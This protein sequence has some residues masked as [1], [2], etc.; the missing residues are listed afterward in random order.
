ME[1]ASGSSETITEKKGIASGVSEKAVLITGISVLLG[2]CFDYSFYGKAPGINFPLYIILLVAGLLFIAKRIKQEVTKQVFWLLTPLLFFSGMVS[3]RSSHLLNFLD[4]TASFLLLLIIA[5]LM[6]GR[7]VRDFLASDYLKLCL[8]PLRFIRPCKHTFSVLT[9]VAVLSGRKNTIA[10]I[11]KGLILSVPVLLLFLLLFSSADLIFHK[12][13]VNLVTFHIEAETI[14][15]L[16]L[17]II[18]SIILAGAFS[19][20]FREV[21]AAVPRELG[22]EGYKLGHI[23]TSILLGS[24]NILFFIF[25]FIQLRYLFGGQSNILLQGFTYAV[26]ARR[27]FFELI[28]VAVFSFLLLWTTEKSIIQTASGHTILFKLLAGVLI[29]QVMLIMVSAFKRLS[30]YEEAYG[31]TT[32]RLYSHVF[33]LFQATIFLLLLYKLLKDNRDDAFAFRSFA[34]V[35]VFLVAMNLLNPDAFIARHNIARFAAGGEIDVDY[36]RFLSDDAVP[37]TIKLLDM[38]NFEGKADLWKILQPVRNRWTEDFFDR[39]QSFNL[40]RMRAKR[41]LE[42]IR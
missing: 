28:A 4:I 17:V 18:V 16:F 33:I 27:G 40:S 10:Q 25:I 26:Y 35:I 5:E 34:V 23:E 12:H 8:L 2:L 13:L 15:R 32:L 37:E 11:L 29:V 6:T 14:V 22:N 21:P 36:L 3:I 38:E 41:I 7:K 31:F 39:W 20:T 24:V 42:A 9:Q 30:L 19:Y 1:L